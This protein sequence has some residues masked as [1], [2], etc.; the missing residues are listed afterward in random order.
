[1]TYQDNS[2]KDKDARQV[3]KPAIS[4]RGGAGRGQ[5]RKK[6]YPGRVGDLQAIHVPSEIKDSANRLLQELWKQKLIHQS[7]SAEELIS[8]LQMQN[9]LIFDDVTIPAS[10]SF[11][12]NERLFRV[13][14]DKLG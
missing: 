4:K 11:S 7:S 10:F 5:G 9:L 1:M 3:S 12:E 13:Q 2:G 6:N 8:I 14:G